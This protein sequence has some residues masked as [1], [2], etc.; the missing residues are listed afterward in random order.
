[1]VITD[2]S[3]FDSLTPADVFDGLTHADITQLTIGKQEKV[4]AA[5]S[6][7][8]GFASFKYFTLGFVVAAVFFLPI[9]YAAFFGTG[10]LSVTTYAVLLIIR[11]TLGMLLALIRTHIYILE[12]F[13]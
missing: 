2:A 7:E 11:C 6:K 3:V 5:S 10:F 8:N 13:E 4:K 1:M 9:H 12:V